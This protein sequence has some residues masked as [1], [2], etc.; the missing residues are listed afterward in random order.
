MVGRDE[1]LG[2]I[3][4]RFVVGEPARVGV[5]VRA[6]DRQ[7]CDRIVELA[8]DGARLAVRREQAVGVQGEARGGSGHGENSLGALDAIAIASNET[9]HLPA[10]D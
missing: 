2:R 1:E 8:R 6:D 5:T 3:G 7:A 9:G 10:M 4:K